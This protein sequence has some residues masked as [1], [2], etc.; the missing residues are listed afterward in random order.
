[1]SMGALAWVVLV[2]PAIAVATVIGTGFVTVQVVKKLE[3]WKDGTHAALH[4]RI[5]ERLAKL[6]TADAIRRDREERE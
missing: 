5:D 1:M 2:V 6:E 4:A 3:E